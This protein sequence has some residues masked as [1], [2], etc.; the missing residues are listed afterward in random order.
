MTSA[1]AASSLSFQVDNTQ[2]KARCG[3]IIVGE[4]TLSTP[5]FLFYTK[6]GSVDNLTKDLLNELPH[7]STHLLQLLYSD[8]V[9]FSEALEK[10]GK[11]AHQFLAYPEHLLFISMRD[12]NGYQEVTFNEQSFMVQTR[13][14][15]QKISAEE[16]LKTIKAIKPDFFSSLS[17]DIQWSTSQKKTK[18]QIVFSKTSLDTLLADKTIDHSTIFANIHG[19]K[20]EEIILKSNKETSVKNVG[21]FIL[22]NFGTNE[23]PED[24]TIQIP[25]L[26]EMLPNDKPRLI[27]GLGSPEDILSLVEMG[28]DLFNTSYPSTVTEWGNALSF[29]YNFEQLKKNAANATDAA[30]AVV[31]ESKLNLWDV[32]FVIDTTAIIPGCPCFACKNH[33]KA[34][35]HHLLNTH[36]MLAQVLLTI[37]NTSHYLGFFSEI[38]KSIANQTFAEYKTLF[39]NQRTL[40][41]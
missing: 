4:K 3:K 29:E 30:A 20:D 35:I 31:T 41:Q 1:T 34:Y 13:K 8:I 25:K 15:N 17:L 36:E 14:G 24:R 7:S 10:Y 12:S 40:N 22:A 37:H 32:K 28:V 16:F 27:T 23:S 26:I 33:N 18:K 6:Q 5:T 9:Q 39:L 11:G 21:G 2:D 19:N 38:Q